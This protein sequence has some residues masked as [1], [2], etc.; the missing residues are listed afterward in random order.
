M[1]FTQFPET[2]LRFGLVMDIDK[3]ITLA[4]GTVA[5]ILANMA[6]VVAWTRQLRQGDRIVRN[7]QF[8]LNPS[9]S[10]S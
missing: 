6:P 5:V 9:S 8:R 4:N 10:C 1:R 7:A 3:P 2:Q